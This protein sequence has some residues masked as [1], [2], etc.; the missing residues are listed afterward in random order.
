MK[1]NLNWN[2][3]RN[4]SFGGQYLYF[5]KMTKKPHNAD[6]DKGTSELEEM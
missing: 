2:R 1:V 3:F 4:I 5:L 6:A